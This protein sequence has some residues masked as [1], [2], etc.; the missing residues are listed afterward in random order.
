MDLLHVTVYF[1]TNADL[2]LY[3]HA[4][5]L[6]IILE[7]QFFVPGKLLKLSAAKLSIL[8]PVTKE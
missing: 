5:A 4:A 7:V 1:T 6:S 8:K 2:D 3:L